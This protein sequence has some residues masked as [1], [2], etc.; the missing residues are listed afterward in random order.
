MVGLLESG[1][2]DAR[3]RILSTGAGL[4]GISALGPLTHRV[5]RRRSRP[6]RERATVVNRPRSWASALH[7]PMPATRG[8]TI[9]GAGVTSAGI[10]FL[11]IT[12][13]HIVLEDQRAGMSPDEIVSADPSLTLSDVHAALA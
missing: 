6:D 1:S 2:V 5:A 4:R 12:V 13:K 8:I 7:F 3:P 9:R 11:R 10:F